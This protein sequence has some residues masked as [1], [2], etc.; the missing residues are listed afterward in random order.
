MPKHPVLMPKHLVLLP[1]HP[2]YTREHL[3]HT[4]AH[5]SCVHERPV[6]PSMHA[7]SFRALAA[8]STPRGS[9]FSFRDDE[10]AIEAGLT[11]ERGR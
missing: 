11:G 5:L 2:V 4:H 7:S 3:V 6:C 9:L 8:R 1:E 10:S